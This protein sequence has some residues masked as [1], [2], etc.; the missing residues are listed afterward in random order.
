MRALKMLSQMLAIARIEVRFFIKFP[1]LLWAALGVALISALYA[2]I[3]L[4]RGGPPVPAIW[5]GG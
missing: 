1:K 4:G 3:Y 5:R 2:V